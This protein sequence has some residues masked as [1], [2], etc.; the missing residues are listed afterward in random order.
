MFCNNCGKEVGV[1]MSFCPSCGAALNGASPRAQV[2]S[3]YLNNGNAYHKQTGKWWGF[4]F[5]WLCS[6]LFQ[7]LLGILYALIL[8][9]LGVFLLFT[10][11]EYVGSYLGLWVTTILAIGVEVLF[12]IPAWR[13]IIK[14]ALN[15]G[16]TIT[17]AV[18]LYVIYS[19]KC[20]VIVLYNFLLIALWLTIIGFIIVYIMKIIWF[21]SLPVLA[22]EKDAEGNEKLVLMNKEDWEIVETFGS[23]Y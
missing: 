17:D 11:Q 7:S 23:T 18:K 19:I 15:I 3:P 10:G 8:L 1:N 22:F 12:L 4:Y 9:I 20:L 14:P 5:G 16:M 2:S 13:I 21:K 6:F